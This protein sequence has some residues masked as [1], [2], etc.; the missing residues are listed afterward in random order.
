M[1]TATHYFDVDTTFKSNVFH[2][3]D[4]K[5]KGYVHYIL[6]DGEEPVPADSASDDIDVCMHSETGPAKYMIGTYNGYY[7][8]FQIYCLFN[9]L[10]RYDGPAKLEKAVDHTEEKWYIHGKRIDSVKYKSWL[11]DQ[12]MDIDNL[13]DEDK[14]LI[15]MKWGS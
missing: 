9:K 4:L 13:S 11:T 10:H 6:E 5:Y 7:Y 15:N 12:G 14:L 8:L 2:L 1:K 3:N